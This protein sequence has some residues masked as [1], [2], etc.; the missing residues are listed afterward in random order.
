[1][2]GDLIE[3]VER[4]P[5]AERTRVVRTD[6]YGQRSMLPL[7]DIPGSAF[8][9]LVSVAMIVVGL[10]SF[11]KLADKS[12]EQAPTVS[13]PPSFPSFSTAP[14]TIPT[15]DEFPAPPTDIAFIGLP[16][17]GTPPTAPERAMELQRYPVHGGVQPAEGLVRL[18]HDG[19]MIWYELYPSRVNDQSTGYL[20]Q[21]LSAEGIRLVTTQDRLDLKDPMILPGWLP[22]SAWID[23]VVRPFVPTTYAACLN[24]FDPVPSLDP[25]G[26]EPPVD[27]VRITSALPTDAAG[28]LLANQP[29]PTSD[30]GR[31][32]MILTPGDARRLDGTLR[33]AG[34]TQD[35]FQNRFVLQYRFDAT[36]TIDVEPRFPDGSV[37]CSACR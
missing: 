27:L 16:P 13:S 11:Q 8:L 22:P 34:L 9:T 1:M 5:D 32:C 25:G 20:E 7:P 24:G 23:P 30:T 2:R 21:R 4:D 37:P 18:F 19:R 33:T 12:Q 17:E 35:A 28:I 36:R 3:P 29:L 14:S 6:R 26:F 10:V 15:L 31:L